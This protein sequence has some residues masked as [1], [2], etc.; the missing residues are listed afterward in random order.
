MLSH[1]SLGV[2]D[3][4]RSVAFYDA[5]LAPLGVERVWTHPQAAGYGPPGGDDRLALFQRAPGEGAPLA[6]GEGFHLAF[7]APD[8]DAVRAFHAAALAHGGTDK[9]PPGLRPRYGANYFAAFARDPDGHKLEVKVGPH[10]R[11]EA[12]RLETERLLLTWPSPEQVDGYYDDIVGS[13][14]FETLLWDGPDGP[15]DLH[16]YWRSTRRVDPDDPTLPL[17]LAVIEEATGRYVGGVALRP[18]PGDPACAEL[19]YAFAPHAHGRGLATEAV[20][21]LVRHAVE[22]RGARR[23]TAGVFVGNTASRRVVEKLGFVCEGVARAGVP[24]GEGRK[25]QWVMAWI[26]AV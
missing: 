6:A 2:S 26:P 15:E 18:A 4:A 17:S 24:K 9:G 16:D 20:E 21:R 8:A 11:F 22:V 12:P 10:R 7:F 5:A 13:D 1:L 23:L 14:I 3:L 25:D 19:G